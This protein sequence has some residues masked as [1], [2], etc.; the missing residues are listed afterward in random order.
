MV[1]GNLRDSLARLSIC[2]L[3]CRSVRS[4]SGVPYGGDGGGSSGGRIGSAN[5][6]LKGI[7]SAAAPL[8]NATTISVAQRW[9]AAWKIAT[10]GGRSP[11]HCNPTGNG[12]IDGTSIIECDLDEVACPSGEYSRICQDHSIRGT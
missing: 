12:R 7:D 8:A 3:G 10:Q 6:E 4:R 5:D 11:R 9:V 2:A 1:M